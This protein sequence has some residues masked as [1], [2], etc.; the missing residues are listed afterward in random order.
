MTILIGSFS[1]AQFPAATELKPENI[2]LDFLSSEGG[3]WHDC[4]HQ[5]GKE[6][7]AWTVTCGPEEFSLHL[8]LREFNS[9]TETTFELH[10]WATRSPS[11]QVRTQST[12]LTVDKLTKTKRILSYIG[13]DEDTTQLRLEIN[14]KT[15]N[16]NYSHQLLGTIK[17]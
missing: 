13:F 16:T 15:A 17:R 11:K 14:F 1:A 3:F 7:Y 8:L 10:Y 12:W 6:P 4:I 5:K 2:S 9:A